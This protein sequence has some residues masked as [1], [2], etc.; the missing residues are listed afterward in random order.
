[1]LGKIPAAVVVEQVLQMKSSQFLKLALMPEH[2][3]CTQFRQ[4]RQFIEF[5]PM[6]FLHTHGNSTD[7]IFDIETLCLERKTLVPT[8]T[9][10]PFS[11][12]PSF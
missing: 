6:P 7:A 1:M 8:F 10:S 11:S 3:L 9:L 2:C 5:A 12:S 4:I